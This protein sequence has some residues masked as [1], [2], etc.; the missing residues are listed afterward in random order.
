[1]NQWQLDQ[2]NNRVRSV[3]RVADRDA[4]RALPQVGTPR[5]ANIEMTERVR[6]RIMA[7]T[8]FNARNDGLLKEIQQITLTYVIG[9]GLRLQVNGGN[10]DWQTQVL[11]LWDAFCRHPEISGR[12]T[13]DQLQQFICKA[14]DYDGEIFLA[15][16]YD[17]ATKQPPILQIIESEQVGGDML[18]D[19]NGVVKDPV[20]GRPVAYNIVDA[21]GE[22][23]QYPASGIVHIALF[24]RPS[25]DRGTPDFETA[26]NGA[27]DRYM[28]D[29]LNMT[30]MQE[31]SCNVMVVEQDPTKMD[32]LDGDDPEFSHRLPTPNLVE[33]APAGETQEEK[34]ERERETRRRVEEWRNYARNVGEV[35]AENIGGKNIV[36]QPG[37]SARLLAT[38]SPSSTYLPYMQQRMVQDCLG[39]AVSYYVID[40][41]K[42]GGASM[43]SIL[44]LVNSK[45][46]MRQDIIIRALRRTVSWLIA[47]WIDM[48]L[49]D[50]VDDFDNVDFQTPA[51]ITADYGRDAKTDREDLAA[52]IVSPRDN[53]ES[54]G[55]NFRTQIQQTI[56]DLTWVREQCEAN[57]LD[58]ALVL[59]VIFQNS[60]PAPAAA[61]AAAAPAATPAEQPA[62]PSTPSIS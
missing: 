30:R 61:P 33:T 3:S 16:I 60:A 48:E 51:R 47:C 45:F 52:G 40:P 8:R 17:P 36:L 13:M 9:S 22:P 32:P 53:F 29:S 42:A 39:T 7:Q 55:L 10:A 62:D 15:L 58:P 20:T 28:L 19:S 26:I 25:S 54:R 11:A 5:S 21:N 14:M 34:E 1:M 23:H 41:T 56:D 6:R 35:L 57:G 24:E 43:R 50:Y 12:F 49:I 46:G 44:A 31:E 27:F 2:A 18:D 38:A 37:Q 4:L 59:N